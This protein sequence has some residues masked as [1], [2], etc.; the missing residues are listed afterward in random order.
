MEKE[1]CI[2]VIDKGKGIE[3][4]FQN[5]IFDRLF[6]LEDSRSR[7]IQ[8]NGLGLTIAKHLAQRLGGDLTVK[9]TPYVETV[10]SF[11]LKKITY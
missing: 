6:T 5:Q 1:V 8:G 2:N 3:K 7:K 11:K 4:A 10:F 9:S